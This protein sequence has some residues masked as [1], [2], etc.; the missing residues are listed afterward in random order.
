M[1]LGFSIWDLLFDDYLI[2]EYMYNYSIR[3][4]TFNKQT[5]EIV[6][7]YTKN[8]ELRI[9]RVLFIKTVLKNNIS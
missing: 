7:N 9:N 6:H 8:N 1:L 3:N 5:I 4:K 2:G